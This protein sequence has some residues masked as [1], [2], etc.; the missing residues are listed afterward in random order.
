MEGNV[1]IKYKMFLKVKRCAF[2]L[3]TL[4]IMFL[5]TT[6]YDP[7]IAVMVENYYGINEEGIGY[8]FLLPLFSF[9]IATPIITQILKRLHRR[10]VI[11][12]SLIAATFG[13]YL[14]GPS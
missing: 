9:C 1:K 3:S 11:L 13:L 12:L 14:T 8:V 5:V 2:A 10:V 4:I 6:W 7:V